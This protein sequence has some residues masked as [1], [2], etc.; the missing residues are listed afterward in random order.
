VQSN[1][2]QSATPTATVTSRVTVCPA[3]PTTTADFSTVRVVPARHYSISQDE[4]TAQLITNKQLGQCMKKVA[5]LLSRRQW[6]TPHRVAATG[7]Q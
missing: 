5:S 1:Q 4:L 2:Q 7:A 6:V 3:L